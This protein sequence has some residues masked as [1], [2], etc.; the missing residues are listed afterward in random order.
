MFGFRE[1]REPVWPSSS[2]PRPSLR[3]PSLLCGQCCSSSCSSVWD[4]PPCLAASRESWHR[5]RIWT[6]YRSAGRRRSTQVQPHKHYNLAVSID[7]HTWRSLSMCVCVS[8]LVC[9]VSFGLA[10][11]FAQGS[12]EYWLALFDSFA[13]SIPLLI[14]AF[15]EMTAVVYIYGIDRWWLHSKSFKNWF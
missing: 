4:C 10:I 8:G 12:G 9:F 14:I 1:S 11:I 5:C 2:S 15:C 13:G 3:C 6:S 7:D